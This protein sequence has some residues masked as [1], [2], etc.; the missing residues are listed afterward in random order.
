RRRQLQAR[1]RG[2]RRV[3]AGVPAR[4]HAARPRRVARLR[5]TRRRRAAARRRGTRD[6]R[7]APG[8]ALA[9][10]L[11]GGGASARGGTGMT[12]PSCGTENRE[13]RKFCSECG[14]ALASACPS[15]GAPNEPGEKFCGD[16]GHAL[17]EDPPETPPR[18]AVA[19]ERRLVSVLFAD[20][21]GF[22]TLSERDRKS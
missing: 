22:T 18:P 21:V 4:E 12:C 9:R 6:V 13:G 14:T 20:L 10:A 2:L 5:R 1:S 17:V 16:C 11:R 19:A 15:C 8:H 7:S 3:R